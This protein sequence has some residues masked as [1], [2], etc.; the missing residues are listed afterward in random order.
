[1]ILK[2][3][4]ILP[5]NTDFVEKIISYIDRYPLVRHLVHCATES[6]AELLLFIS[7]TTLPRCM[8]FL[9]KVSPRSI[10]KR[11]FARVANIGCVST[12]DKYEHIHNMKT[13]D[14][15]QFEPFHDSNLEV[16]R[17]GLKLMS[18]DFSSR[19]RRKRSRI[20]LVVGERMV[21]SM[22]KR[23]SESTKQTAAEPPTRYAGRQEQRTMQALLPPSL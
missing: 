14:L 17:E 15:F 18:L 5:N 23:F 16:R 7:Q 21:F 12:T 8:S 2:D 13:E 22:G 9:A 4:G 11:A 10:L 6:G 1:M 3:H 19:G 20:K